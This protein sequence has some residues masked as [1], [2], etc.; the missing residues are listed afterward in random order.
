LEAFILSTVPLGRAFRSLKLWFVLRTYGA[1]ALRD[2][3]RHHIAL[4]AKFEEWVRA[5]DRFELVAPRMFSLVCF[6]L[7]GTGAE[8]NEANR[9]LLEAVNATGGLFLTHTVLDGKFTI[10]IA[11]CGTNTKEEHVRGAWEE[12]QKAVAAGVGTTAAAAAAAAK[13]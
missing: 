3:I 4:A 1:R 11:I 10:R 9:Q 6:R 12:V 13:V 2:Y 8:A 5:D 7:K